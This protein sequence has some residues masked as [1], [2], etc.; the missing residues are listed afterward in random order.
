MPTNNDL[1][2]LPRRIWWPWDEPARRVGFY[3]A[4]HVVCP[5]HAGTAQATLHVSASGPFCAWLDDRWLP[6]PQGSLPPWRQ[7]RRF[8]F[9]LPPGPHALNILAASG[10][11]GQPFLLA[12][13]D[14]PQPGG[15]AR[16]GTDESW[17][18][19][20][21]PPLEWMPAI[22]EGASIS[23]EL[24]PPGQHAIEVDELDLL[25]EIDA[26]RYAFPP[27]MRIEVGDQERG[28]VPS[29]PKEQEP[30]ADPPRKHA[31]T[32]GNLLQDGRTAAFEFE[33]YPYDGVWA[34]PW[35]MP[36]DAPDDFCRLSTGWQRWTD[37]RLTR[38]SALHQGLTA[39]GTGVWAHEDGSLR[40]RPVAPMPQAP[41][42]LD[43][44]RPPGRWHQVRESHSKQVNSWLDQYEARA[45]HAILDVGQDTFG[46]VRVRLKRGGPA[47][48]A[49]T[50]GESVP[51][52]HRYD[53][54]STDVFRLDN[55]GS[56]T[57]TPTGFR[58]AKLIALGTPHGMLDVEPLTVQHIRH[59]VEP[60]GRFTCSDPLLNRIWDACA[61]TLHLCMQ[62]E[63]WDAI[64]RDQLPWMCELVTEALAAYHVFGDARLVRRSLAA[65]AELGPAPARPLERQ[66][67]P[68]LQAV[69]K[70]EG[71]ELNG[72]PTCTL[73]WVIGMADYVRYT[74]D[75]SLLVEY[76]P[77]LLATLR[78]IVR[79]LGSDGL[80]H[81]RQ[82]RNTEAWTP[83][84]VSGCETCCHLLACLAL[85]LGADMVASLGRLDAADYCS[86][87]WL[88]VVDAA[89]RAW[90]GSDLQALQ[91][92]I[93]DVGPGPRPQP[94]WDVPTGGHDI[95]P[96]HHAYAMAI[97][98]GCLTPQEAAE[99][100]GRV[101]TSDPPYPMTYWHRYS[102]LEAAAQVGQIQ[103]GLDCL[104]QHWGT[105]LEAGMST[106]WESFDPS[107]LGHDP[108]GMS[109][110]TGENATY[111]GYRTSH[112]YGGATG[113][114]AWLHR[115]VLG[116]V[117]VRDGFTAA[118]FAPAL[119]DLAWARGSIPTPHGPIHVSLQRRP[120]ALPRA[121]IA[122]PQ[123]IE[124]RIGEEVL[125]TW[126]IEEQRYAESEHR[127]GC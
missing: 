81:L 33:A 109:I 25:I 36:A 127:A 96:T 117:P 32:S 95:G 69:W 19:V 74:G 30:H 41:P 100:F 48:L 27:G 121:E 13:L 107:W 116:V 59:P 16:I 84:S 53:R 85:S 12:C 10:D 51:E 91:S 103:W 52:I 82:N 24:V 124:L 70:K 35:G 67:Y 29:P 92:A 50:T 71:G 77:E 37:E 61:H 76:T 123:A 34:E 5:T 6:V 99:L 44:T 39:A 64:K 21:E 7:M 3:R 15:L 97:R 47:I 110:V 104:R 89:R 106:L 112:C 17:H 126:E 1:P 86:A 118:R 57:T 88:R 60:A 90:F 9:A 66:L 20:I 14:W 78:H 115:A 45:P 108:H 43:N 18:A 58:F 62:N 114:A 38:V 80:W 113:P 98:S 105:A 65:L 101:Q 56:F 22:P 73:W 119:G 31:R 120:G 63:I 8:E 72:V 49:L 2:P 75:R 46:R 94:V 83:L 23:S 125:R 54:R 122:L 87:L 40:M 26:W 11:H 102:D 79:H 4:F 55:G 28:N 68:G 111:G 42:E 93:T